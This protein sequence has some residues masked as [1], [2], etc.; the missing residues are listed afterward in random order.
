M[1]ESYASEH[2]DGPL[3]PSRPLW[4]QALARIGRRRPTLVAALML[5]TVIAGALLATRVSPYDPLEMHADAML[6][7][8][9]RTYLLGTDECGRD[10]LSRLLSGSR[11]SLTIA[12]CSVIGSIAAGTVLGLASAY[13]GGLLDSLIMRSVD[14]LMAFPWLL[15]GLLIVSVL[16]PGLANAVVAIAVLGIPTVARM[17]RAGVL[18]ERRKE[19]VLAAESIGASRLQTSIRHILPNV[20]PILLVVGSLGAA[21]AILTEAALSFLGLG[22]QP[23]Q[24]SWGL[25]LRRGYNHFTLAPWYVGFPG[26]AVV[27]VVWS[28]NT[29]GDGLREGLDP[30]LRGLR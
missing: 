12:A 8:P 1:S 30:R 11:A 23:P 19:Y 7:R 26:L 22:V 28:L 24:A 9:S 10:L 29:L 18:V 5:V 3:H 17:T 2:V 20:V 4:Q 25:L 16:G 14:A 6:A 27:L 21:N 15:L 13:V